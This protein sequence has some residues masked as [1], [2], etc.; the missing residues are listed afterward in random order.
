MDYIRA[1]VVGVVVGALF[2]GLWALLYYVTGRERIFLALFVGGAVGHSMGWV[3]GRY[4]DLAVGGLAMVIAMGSIAIGKIAAYEF[5]IQDTTLRGPAAE[6]YAFFTFVDNETFWAMMREE[7]LEWPDGHNFMTVE[8]TE[9]FPRDIV[10]DCAH[11]WNEMSQAELREL[12]RLARVH[13]AWMIAERA[14]EI[15]ET[16]ASQ[17]HR[18]TPALAPK[19]DESA[20]IWNTVPAEAWQA[21]IDEWHSLDDARK[22]TRRERHERSTRALVRNANAEHASEHIEDEFKGTD[23]FYFAFASIWAFLAG[24]GFIGNDD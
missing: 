12:V 8:D 3:S 7:Q 24:M 23:L 15:A 4:A 2:A 1:V 20:M 9:D 19:H 18:L 13:D 11:R 21:A 22:L 10:L 6:E 14:E 17:R 16:W 5:Y